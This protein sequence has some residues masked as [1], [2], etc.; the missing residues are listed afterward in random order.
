MNQR[1]LY[2]VHNQKVFEQCTKVMRMW[3]C[4]DVCMQLF[5]IGFIQNVIHL[6][7]WNVCRENFRARIRVRSWYAIIFTDTYICAQICGIRYRLPRRLARETSTYLYIQYVLASSVT[8]ESETANHQ[9]KKSLSKCVFR[10]ANMRMRACPR[11]TFL[12]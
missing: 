1:N 9:K 5:C 8:V 12:M 6:S 3:A 7:R 10:N 2:T 4:L 11:G